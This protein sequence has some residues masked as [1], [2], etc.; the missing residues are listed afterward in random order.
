MAV[1]AGTDRRDLELHL[2]RSG[3]CLVEISFN[4][5]I[6]EPLT[7]MTSLPITTGGTEWVSDKGFG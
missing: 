7:I 5:V 4:S 3:S 1:E 6:L 2:L